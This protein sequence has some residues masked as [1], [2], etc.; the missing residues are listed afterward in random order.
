MLH[1]KRQTQIRD[2]IQQGRQQGKQQ[3]PYNPFQRPL[4]APVL[5]SATPCILMYVFT[6]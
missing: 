2:C 6:N 5:Q 1:V 3:G 4:N